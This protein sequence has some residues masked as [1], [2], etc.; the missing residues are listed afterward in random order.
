MVIA[1]SGVA[2]CLGL[3]MTA[4]A[5]T[6]SVGNFPAPVF[7][8]VAMGNPATTLTLS[9]DPSG[10]RR[11]HEIGDTLTFSDPS[12]FGGC[13]TDGADIVCS[14]SVEF[15]W[16]VTNT[17][18]PATPPPPARDVLIA[19]SATRGDVDGFFDDR[20]DVRT[21]SLMEAWLP[22]GTNVPTFLGS[23]IVTG[24]QA[25]PADIVH[26][27]S[28]GLSSPMAMG[29]MG[30]G[31]DLVIGSAGAVSAAG[32]G[33]DDTLIGSSAHDVLDGGADSDTIRGG[34][35]PDTLTA[36]SGFVDVLSY[37]D[38]ARTSPLATTFVRGTATTLGTADD[39]AGDTISTGFDAIEGTP[40]A[41]NLTAGA[42]GAGLRGAGG[43]DVLQGGAA[44]DTFAGGDGADDIRALDGNAET[45]DCGPGLDVA[46]T[47]DPS[48]TLTGCEGPPPADQAP[49][50]E[51]APAAGP[52]PDPALAAVA[53]VATAG[54]GAG[55]ATGTGT[56]PGAT[57]KPALPVIAA[58]LSAAFGV[59][60]SSTTVTTLTAKQLPAG[61]TVAI[62]CTAPKGKASACAFKA[63]SRSFAKTTAS[64]SFA[65]LFKKRK[66]PVR[67][68]V[69]VRITAPGV[70]G[71]SFTFTTRKGKQPK[72]VAAAT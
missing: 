63:K 52:Q 33:G 58:T 69:V 26:A 47:F 29:G 68:V 14:A 64:S 19:K 12:G 48:D 31:A 57:G 18:G 36:G 20:L 56:G 3:A 24:T 70:S 67:T 23:S 62:T 45:V 27:G 15:R 43:A 50:S 46:F 4:G 39:G 42:T 41:D 13:A 61:A 53:P 5:A 2:L 72:R 44:I 9:R 6:V 21:A 55:T 11:I 38:A 71:K 28:A 51:P 25:V 34:L 30:A 65:S 40:L 35:G 37:D 32:A 54:A 7:V 10:A 1:T 66:L 16:T 8:T 22:D 17:A 60:G 49:A 59:R